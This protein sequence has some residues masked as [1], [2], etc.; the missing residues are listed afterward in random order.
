MTNARNRARA[1]LGKQGAHEQH[2]AGDQADLGHHTPFGAA[3][4]QDFPAG[5][6]A[7]PG[8]ARSPSM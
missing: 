7:R 5:G 4:A 3:L 1:R 2:A 8:T 6:K